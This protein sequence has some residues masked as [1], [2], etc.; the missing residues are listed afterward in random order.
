MKKLFSFIFVLA[1][2][3]VLFACGKTYKIEISE[4]QANVIVEKGESVT[5]TPSFTDGETLSWKSSNEISIL[6]VLPQANNTKA[7]AN[8]KMKLN[9]FFIK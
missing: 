9:N 3:F 1:M 6:Y 2:A 8:T 7:I 5:I 4:D